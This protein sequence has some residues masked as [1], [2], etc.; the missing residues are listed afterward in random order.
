MVRRELIRRVAELGP[1]ID[2]AIG[3]FSE[4]RYRSRA[5]QAAVDGLFAALVGW[6]RSAPIAST[7]HPIP[8]ETHDV[9]SKL[10][11]ELCTAPAAERRHA[12]ASTRFPWEAP[13]TEPRKTSRRYSPS[14][15]RSR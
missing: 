1:I 4:L 2:E 5:L 9:P 13:G 3:Q 11:A 15:R 7:P 12:W 6:R 14:A 10:P 8:R